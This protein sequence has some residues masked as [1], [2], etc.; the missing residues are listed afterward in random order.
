MTCGPAM[1]RTRP[2]RPEQPRGGW[3]DARAPESPERPRGGWPDARAPESI[4]K[5]AVK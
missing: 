4:A 1:T 5:E 3:P 2:D